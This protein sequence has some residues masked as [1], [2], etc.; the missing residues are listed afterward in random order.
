MLSY[1][2]IIPSPRWERFCCF[3]L[4]GLWLRCVGLGELAA[5]GLDDPTERPSTTRATKQAD[6]RRSDARSLA[7]RLLAD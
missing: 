3:W 2:R 4:D 7:H 5:C 6:S 1:H